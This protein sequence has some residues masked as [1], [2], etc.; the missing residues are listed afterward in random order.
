KPSTNNLVVEQI[1]QKHKVQ[2]PPPDQ[3]HKPQELQQLQ[4]DLQHQQLQPDLQHQQQLQQRQQKLGPPQKQQLPQQLQQLQ[5]LDLQQLQLH[6]QLQPLS[7]LLPQHQHHH[8]FSPVI[9]R[10]RQTSSS[11]WTPPLASGPSTGRSRSN[12][13]MKLPRRSP[14]VLMTSDSVHSFLTS[15]R[16]RYSI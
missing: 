3:R 1:Q 15:R 14:W 11:C 5:H 12:S 4:L 8:R 6:L 16:L 7:Q 10:P 2:P 13:P 9:T